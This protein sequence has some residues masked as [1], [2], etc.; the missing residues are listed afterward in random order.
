MSRALAACLLAALW[1]APAFAQQPTD[2]PLG[3]PL[4]P[5]VCLLSQQEVLGTA[6]IGQA[7]TAQLRQLTQAPAI[8]V[9]NEN[10]TIQAEAKALAAKRATMKAAEYQLQEKAL[11]DRYNQLQARSSQLQRQV[12]ATR[13]KA[14]NQISADAQPVIAQVYKAHNCGLLLD[15]SVVLG[16]NMGG[17]ITSAVVQGLDARVTTITFQLEPPA[18]AGAGQ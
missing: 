2:A 17:D 12:E 5:G 7:A 6:K 11:A 18:P 8:A 1:A 15:R 9:N 10:Q 16:G 4:I 14:L 3:G 13:I